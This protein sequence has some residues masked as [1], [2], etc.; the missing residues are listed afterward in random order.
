VRGR[1]AILAV[2]GCGLAFGGAVALGQGGSG[3]SERP[4]V[5][6]PGG[7]L[8]GTHRVTVRIVPRA[9]TMLSPVNVKAGG[10]VQV[11]LTGL[12]Q[13]ASV[14]VRVRRGDVVVSG[15]SIGG[16][17]FRASRTFHQCAPAPPRPTTPRPVSGGGE[18]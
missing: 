5:R 11:H 2:A 4:L 16:E 8:D 6:I 14:S 10:H 9:N 13:E 12:T 7:C 15:E 17:H 18:G 1:Y 3:G